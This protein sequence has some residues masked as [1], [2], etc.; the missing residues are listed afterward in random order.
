MIGNG[1]N[2]LMIQA[3]EAINLKLEPA[4]LD[5]LYADM[6]S[7]YAHQPSTDTRLYPNAENV[8]K[9]LTDK[10][11]RLGVCTNKAEEIAKTILAD[12]KISQYFTS[13]VG[14][15]PDQPRKPDPFTL[16]KVIDA[17]Y[18]DQ[19][20][21]IM[22]GDSSIDTLAAEATNIPCIVVTFGYTSIPAS[23]LGGIQ[24]VSDLA[25]VPE[26]VYQT[27]PIEDTDTI[28]VM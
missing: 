10:G 11:Y 20:R 25:E 1:L 21:A 4:E 2:R 23:Q 8:L 3:V 5:A 13:I 7:I 14:S 19:S 12:L 24:T 9:E 26:I 27:I 15:L 16:N 28:N 18:S 22:V 6:L 17:C